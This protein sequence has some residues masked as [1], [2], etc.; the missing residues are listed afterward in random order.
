MAAEPLINKPIALDWDARGRLW[1]AETPEYPNGRRGLRP[2]FEGGAE[3]LDHGGLV[4]KAGPAAEKAIETA[5]QVAEKAADKAG[6]LVDKAKDAAGPM[7]EKAKDTAGELLG[8][9]K[10][11]L[12]GKDDGE[13]SD[14]S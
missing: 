14:K 3:W 11:L 12:A 10:G 13:G 2:D 5:G 8:K 6:E 4:D 1:V 9:V 7:A